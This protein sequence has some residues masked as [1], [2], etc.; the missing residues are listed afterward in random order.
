MSS[1]YY[2]IGNEMVSIKFLGGESPFFVGCCPLSVSVPLRVDN[3]RH[4]KGDIVD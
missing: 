4:T 2:D 1:Y 3:Y